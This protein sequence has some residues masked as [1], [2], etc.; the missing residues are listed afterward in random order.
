MNISC[1]QETL[2]TIMGA[3]NSR[4]F[5]C[6]F[7]IQ[8]AENVYSAVVLNSTKWFH[9]GYFAKLQQFFL[10]SIN[11]HLWIPYFRSNFKNR[12]E[13]E[14]KIFI[15]IWGVEIKTLTTWGTKNEKFLNTWFRICGHRS[16]RN[17]EFS[18]PMWSWLF[19][20]EGFEKNDT[21]KPRESVFNPRWRE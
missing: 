21:C 12:F 9:S 1:R 2:L 3:E 13:N 7:I 19:R 5:F 6:H 10:R 20:N 8:Y 4:W 11:L 14:F 18:T 16:C 15:T 17:R